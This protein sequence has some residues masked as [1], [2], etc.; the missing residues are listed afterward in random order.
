MVGCSLLPHACAFNIALLDRRLGNRWQGITLSPTLN[1]DILGQAS[2]THFAICL[3]VSPLKSP[4]YPCRATTRLGDIHEWNWLDSWAPLAKHTL[5][6][7]NES[8]CSMLFKWPRRVWWVG[9]VL[10]LGQRDRWPVSRSTRELLK[11]WN[12]KT[13]LLIQCLD[14]TIRKLTS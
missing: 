5:P 3:F 2:A 14:L 13:G 9:V 10:G 7:Y 8:V 1:T 4:P 11:S 6:F 12:R